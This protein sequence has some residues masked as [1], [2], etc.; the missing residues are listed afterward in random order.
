MFAGTIKKRSDGLCSKSTWAVRDPTVPETRWT[1]TCSRGHER[2]ANSP[3]TI[4]GVVEKTTAWRNP[5]QTFEQIDAAQFDQRLGCIRDYDW[6]DV[7]HRPARL[8]ADA[9]HCQ[10]SAAYPYASQ[11]DSCEWFE[12]DLKDRTSRAARVAGDNAAIFHFV[13]PIASIGDDGIM[14]RQKQGFPALLH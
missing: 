13:N 14:G 4:S 12:R 10:L 7:L 9:A 1:I 8:T 5:Q 6:Q 11:S 2:F 3:P